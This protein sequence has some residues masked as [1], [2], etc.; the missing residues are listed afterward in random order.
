MKKWLYLVCG[1]VLVAAVA[2][3]FVDKH[4]S[5]ARESASVVQGERHTV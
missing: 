4:V 1:V 2:R 5:N 3:P